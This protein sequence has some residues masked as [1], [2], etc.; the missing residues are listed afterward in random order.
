MLTMHRCE[1]LFRIRESGRALINKL[2]NHLLGV[3]VKKEEW[4]IERRAG[5]EEKNGKRG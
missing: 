5:E 3:A 2:N 4:K 1:E